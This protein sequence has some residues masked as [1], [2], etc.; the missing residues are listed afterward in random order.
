LDNWLINGVA[1]DAISLDDRGLHYGD[2]LFETI[3]VRDCNCRFLAAHLRRLAEGCARLNIPVPDELDLHSELQQLTKAAR[4]ATVKIILTR[5]TG[6][7]GYRLPEKCTPTRIVGIQH[8]QPVG[9]PRSGV[10]VRYCATPISRNPLLAG[11]K[12]LNRLEQVMARAEW[13]D[14]EI[15]EGLML[16]DRHEIVCG[17]MTNVFFGRDGVLFTPRLAE[18]GIS[19]IMRQQV[20][21]VAE[22]RGIEVRERSVSKN[23]LSSADEVFL[24]NSL[25]GLW[26]VSNL[27][28]QVFEQGALG[29]A[30]SAGLA[31]RGV[32]ECAP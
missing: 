23:D 28:G 20:L 27:E 26:P 24:T 15:A 25:I 19:G 13:N 5:G 11:L 32:M 14:A 22:E 10:K 6:P 17:T 29:T 31:A 18:C 16:N 4:H 8:T 12:T 7:R 30:I 21:A 3:A 2:G 1:A 9:L